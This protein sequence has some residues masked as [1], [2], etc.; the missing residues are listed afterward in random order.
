V[1]TAGLAGSVAASEAADR[2][3][4]IQPLLIGAAVPSVEL[5]T[6]DGETVDLQKVIQGKRSI[7]LFYRGGW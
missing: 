3:E 2:A 5:R 4:D 1:A 7:L 6:L